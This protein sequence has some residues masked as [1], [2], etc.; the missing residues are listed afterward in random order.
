MSEL[1]TVD[2]LAERLGVSPNWVRDHARGSRRP[3]I[4]ALK[5]G[6]AWRFRWEAIE[7]W[8]KELEERRVA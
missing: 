2:Q 1:L 5:L 7:A 3:H 8:L 4:P 6:G